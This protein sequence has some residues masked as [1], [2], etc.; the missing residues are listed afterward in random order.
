VDAALAGEAR[1]IQVE[2]SL[3][4][5]TNAP[6]GPSGAVADVR[7]DGA[8]VYSGTQRPFIVRAAAAGITGL[9][10][11][12]IEVVAMRSSGTYGRNMADDAALEAVRLSH[13]IKQPV[14]VQ[15]TRE[16]E[17]QCS[18]Y[19]PAAFIEATAALTAD[20]RVAAWRYAL[21]THAHIA[22]QTESA[23]LAAV[24]AGSGAFPPYS[25]PA[26][27]IFLHVERAPIRTAAF[28]SLA[29]AE[30]VFAIESLMDELAAL[31]GEDPISF[32]RKHISDQRLAAVLDLV[33]ERSGWA[34]APKGGG[35]GLGVA[36]TVFDHTPCAMVADVGV[37][38]RGR[39]RVHRIWC[40]IDPGLTINPDGVR[41]QVEGAILQATS[42]AL[43]EELKHRNGRIT[44]SGWDTYPIVTFREAPS[45]EV[46]VAGLAEYD[47]TGVGEI[48][49][50]PPAAAIANAVFA[51]S[52]VRVRELPLTPDRVRNARAR[53]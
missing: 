38:D 24:T 11:S 49:T 28:R 8:T 48:G 9:A 6:I 15:W 47:S 26:A 13:A 19:R 27:A 31:A 42:V 39:V 46:I 17:F 40:A 4:Y 18:S 1:T 45:I 52:G 43:M 33:A 3:P 5:L 44:T 29:G 23:Q 35:R 50:V 37:D 25:I 21:A 34:G 12:A 41:N 16:D 22:H 7:G 2:Y 30:N 53:A 14:L 51:A 10:E 32:R 20:N 36:C